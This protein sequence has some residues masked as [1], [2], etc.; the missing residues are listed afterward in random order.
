MSSPSEG[1]G[2]PLQPINAPAAKPCGPWGFWATLGWLALATTLGLMLALR[3]GPLQD[4]VF[5]VIAVGVLATAAWSSRLPVENYFALQWPERKDLNYLIAGFAMLAAIYALEA[6]LI[7]LSVLHGNDDKRQIEA[8]LEGRLPLF[9]FLALAL[10]YAP[11]CEE[12]I[13]RGFIFRGWSQTYLGPVGTI[14]LTALLFGLSHTYS[15]YAVLDTTC[16]GLVAGWT[17]WRSRSIIVPILLHVIKNCLATIA[18]FFD[19]G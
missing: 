18:G 2:T 3:L 6:L 4:L 7:Y 17:R 1:E 9:L 12:L 5:D 14:W 19:D 8:Q 13:F 16:F 11:V 15:I 10:I